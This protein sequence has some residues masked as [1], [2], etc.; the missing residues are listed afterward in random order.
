[1]DLTC[2]RIN[3]RNVLFASL[4]KSLIF[5]SEIYRRKELYIIYSTAMFLQYTLDI[6]PAVL[7]HNY[8]TAGVFAFYNI[9]GI[10]GRLR[11]NSHDI[12]PLCSVRLLLVSSVMGK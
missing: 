11:E 5:P 3:M 12:D 9:Q 4:R 10:V 1:M 7:S 6:N 8:S 2:L